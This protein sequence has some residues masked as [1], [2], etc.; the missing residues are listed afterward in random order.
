VYGEVLDVMDSAAMERW[1]ADAEAKMGGIDILVSNVSTR[2]SSEGV[3]R[4]SDAFEVDFLQHVKTAEK[5]LPALEKSTSGSLVF[6]ATIASV[7]ANIMPAEREYGAMKAA[8]IAYA[9][10]LAHRLAPSGVRSN[11]VSPGPIDFP[12]G[13]WDWVGQQQ[14]ELYKRAAQLPALG[15]HGRP[16]EVARAVVFLASPAASYITGA[17]LRVEG[18]ALKQTNF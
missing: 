9:A 18:G 5:V 13:F 4:W 11:I 3:Q 12:G 16:E 15:R 6:V 8:L 1:L 14:P 7:M 17:N 10:Q 2:I